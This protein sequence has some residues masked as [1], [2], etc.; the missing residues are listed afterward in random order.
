LLD[1]DAEETVAEQ[2]ENHGG[3]QEQRMRAQARPKFFRAR[4]G[5]PGG[6]LVIEPPL[7]AG[8]VPTAP[9]TPL[10][11]NYPS[12]SRPRAATS[13]YW[14]FSP[15]PPQK[16]VSQHSESCGQYFFSQTS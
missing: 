2:H 3:E 16:Y 1:H 10:R 6:R 8:D 13:F 15:I 4:V 12:Q 14:Q 7:V 5:A 9:E 11:F